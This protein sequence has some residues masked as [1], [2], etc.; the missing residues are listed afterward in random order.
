MRG[1][2]GLERE[3]EGWRDG[4]G[5]GDAIDAMRDVAGG[6]L[7]RDGGLDVRSEGDETWRR[8][9]MRNEVDGLTG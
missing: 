4:D 6:A 8:G 9:E 1:M 2:R 5:D 3:R 7:R